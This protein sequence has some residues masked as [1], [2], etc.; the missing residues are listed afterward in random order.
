[1]RSF[2]RVLAQYFVR[3]VFWLLLFLLCCLSFLSIPTPLP[4]KYISQQISGLHRIASIGVPHFEIDK[5]Q[6]RQQYRSLFEKVEQHIPLSD[7]ECESYRKIYQQ[8][9]FK[10]QHK[11]SLFDAQLSLVDDLA[12]TEK[13][14]VGGLGV[15]G[16]HDHHDMSSR[17]NFYEIAISVNYLQQ[18]PHDKDWGFSLR[19]V[20]QAIGIYKNLND[21]LFH[22]ATVPHTKSVSYM[23]QDSHS[24]PMQQLFESMLFHFKQAQFLTINTPEYNHQLVLALDKYREL[25]EINQAIIYQS[26]SP[27]ELKLAGNW[28]SWRSLTPKVSEEPAANY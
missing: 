6:L 25:I 4:S 9:L 2:T 1:M 15:E 21:L 22:L 12:M 20:G 23:A 18:Y 26:L 17:N 14:N 10:D 28:G 3:L 5:G 8:L 11:F 16:K 19:R 24:E 13:N 7:E 27:L